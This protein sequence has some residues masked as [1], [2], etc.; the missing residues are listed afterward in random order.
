MLQLKSILNVID[1]SGA[2][3]AE[4]IRVLHGGQYAR[5]GTTN[6]L[7][8]PS[9]HFPFLLQLGSFPLVVEQECRGEGNA[10]ERQQEEL[11]SSHPTESVKGEQGSTGQRK[12]SFR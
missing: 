10:Q 11:D 1:N 8:P 12:W 6:E 7:S 5:I 3:W 2:V 9:F 4:C